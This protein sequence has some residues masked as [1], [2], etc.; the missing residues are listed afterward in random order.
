MRS[1]RDARARSPGAA[2]WPPGAQ[3]AHPP[4]SDRGSRRR[5]AHTAARPSPASCWAHMAR[6]EG[7]RRLNKGRVHDQSQA[8]MHGPRDDAAARLRSTVDPHRPEPSEQI[9]V[10]VCNSPLAAS[11]SSAWEMYARARAARMEQR[12]TAPAVPG[13]KAWASTSA[14][15]R[16]ARTTH[17]CTPAWPASMKTT[18][19]STLSGRSL[20]PKT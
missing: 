5:G 1:A 2:G 18:W 14:E 7:A 10:C 16:R 8:R 11:D 20:R 15:S 12:H 17:A 13:A 4:G 3:P 6:A 9:L 19:W